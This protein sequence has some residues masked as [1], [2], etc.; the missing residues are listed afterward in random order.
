MKIGFRQLLAFS[1]LLWGV[2]ALTT[3]NGQKDTAPEKRKIAQEAIAILKQTCLSCHSG[4]KPMGNLK[5]LTRT[6]L[7]KGGLSGSAIDLAKPNESLLL[8]AVRFQGRQ[9]PPS[10]KLSIKQIEVLAKWIEQGSYGWRTRRVKVYRLP[11][12]RLKLHL[13]P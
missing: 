5:L 9:M 13:S 11:I 2:T 4:D 8:K 12:R 3:V 7:I 1:P 10:G 6:D